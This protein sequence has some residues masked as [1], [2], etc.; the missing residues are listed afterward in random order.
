MS[1]MGK[2]QRAVAGTLCSALVAGCSGAPDVTQP[3]VESAAQAVNTGPPVTVD[4]W[5][6]IPFTDSKCRDGSPTGIGVRLHPGSN[7]LV[8]WLNGGGACFSGASCLVNPRSFGLTDFQDTVRVIASRKGHLKQGI[9]ERT[10]A[11][12]PVR[13]WNQVYIPYCTGDLHAGHAPN[14]SVPGVIGLQQFVG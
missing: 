10:S 4:D 9:F 2:A 5:T 12:N 8:I 1:K 3:V 6:W 14:K 13:D 11:S 7:T